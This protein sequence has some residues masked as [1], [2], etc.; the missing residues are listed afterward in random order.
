M[1][2]VRR[3]RRK[4]RRGKEDKGEKGKVKW[5]HVEVRPHDVSEENVVPGRLASKFAS[6]CACTR[7]PKRHV[8]L[9]RSG[10]AQGSKGQDSEATVKR[11]RTAHHQKAQNNIR[12]PRTMGRS[13]WH[14]GVRGITVLWNNLDEARVPD[15]VYKLALL[16]AT[17]ATRRGGC[18]R[19]VGGGGGS[20]VGELCVVL[21]ARHKL[22]MTRRQ[23]LG[24][25]Q[26]AENKNAQAHV[27]GTVETAGNSRASALL[28]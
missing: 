16:K 23:A 20:S 21:G 4:R 22:D 2:R 13:W 11:P 6:P 10:Q 8:K 27:H 7:H 15:T 12:L 14:A 9:V 17:F 5:Y 18:W 19:S 3:M 24:A 28:R 26:D 1:S 25:Q